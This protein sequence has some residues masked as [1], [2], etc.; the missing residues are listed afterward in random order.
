M[1]DENQKSYDHLSP[2]QAEKAE[3]TAIKLAA[4][5]AAKELKNEDSQW[6]LVQEILQEILAAYLVV[7]PSANPPATKLVEDLNK[8]IEKRYK[9][10]EDVKNLLLESIPSARSVRQWLKKDGWEDAVWQKIRADQLFSAGKRAEV[11]QALRQRAI[12]KSDLAAKIYLT[13]SGDYVEKQEVD[14]KSVDI[15]R[16]INKILHNKKEE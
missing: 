5:K 13:L 6:T 2:E 11:I 3:K 7:D 4:I 14:T 1:S 16:D 8:E 10:E 12:D 9:D 15:Y